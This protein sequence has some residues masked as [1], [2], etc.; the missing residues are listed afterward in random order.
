[1]AIERDPSWREVVSLLQSQSAERLAGLAEILNAE[2]NP[3]NIIDA[4][5]KSSQ[6][7]FSGALGYEP[8][9]RC[10]L[11][12]VAKQSRISIGELAS[13]EEIE[14]A[15]AQRIVSSIVESMSPEQERKLEEQLKELARTFDKTGTLVE[16]GGVIVALTAARLSGFGVYLLASTALGALTAALGVTLPFAAY[17]SMSSTIAVVIGPPCWI[18]LAQSGG[19]RVPNSRR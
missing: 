15:I 11:E 13:P 6:H 19:S 12:R 1:M 17:M 16:S 18:A 14:I 9:Y 5:L 7:R 8:P 3:G 2:A 10:I 4:L